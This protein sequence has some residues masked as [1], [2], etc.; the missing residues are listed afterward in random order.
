MIIGRKSGQVDRCRSQ[1]LG[2][3]HGYPIIISNIPK[4]SGIDSV[5]MVPGAVV[6]VPGAVVM[7]PVRV[8]MVPPNAVEVMAAVNSNAQR[9]D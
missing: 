5:V 2:R 9:I 6:M 1:C 3:Q 8:V 4:S 7:V